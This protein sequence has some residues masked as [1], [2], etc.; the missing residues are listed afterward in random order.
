MKYIPKYY[1]SDF[2][3]NP[4]KEPS[5]LLVLVTSAVQNPDFN[6][7]HFKGKRAKYDP[8]V[9][10]TLLLQKSPGSLQKQIAN[11]NITKIIFS[12]KSW[13]LYK[14]SKFKQKNSTKQQNSLFLLTSSTTP[15][16]PSLL[17]ASSDVHQLPQ[18][19]TV[20]LKNIILFTYLHR[21]KENY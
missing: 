7:F 15:D 1:V 3:Q 21:K 8:W 9:D 10:I 13:V 19:G 4:G 16:S 20:L 2:F 5:F 12:Q 6:L 14:K 11:S 18:R 17:P